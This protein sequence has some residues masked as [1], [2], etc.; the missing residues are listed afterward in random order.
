[1]FDRRFLLGFGSSGW[2]EA[3]FA[4]DDLAAAE[5]FAELEIAAH[6]EEYEGQLAARMPED[7]SFEIDEWRAESKDPRSRRMYA[8]QVE[9]AD[10]SRDRVEAFYASRARCWA[11]LYANHNDAVR[12]TAKVA[13]LALLREASSL[14]AAAEIEDNVS[15]PWG[16][17]VDRYVREH[18]RRW[19]TAHGSLAG[20]SDM[21]RDWGVETAERCVEIGTTLA[22]QGEVVDACR[23]L[24]DPRPLVEFVAEPRSSSTMHTH[25]VLGPEWP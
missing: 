12:T 7:L 20:Y 23:T 13:T 25:G 19:S 24:V 6:G 5:L 3:K 10:E 1:M 21:L 18:P 17:A 9:Q 22:G 16:R 15:S 8:R 11:L 4:A 14:L 2:R